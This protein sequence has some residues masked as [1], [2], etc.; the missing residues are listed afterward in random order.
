MKLFDNELGAYYSKNEQA[1][2]DFVNEL[3]AHKKQRDL[4]DRVV[5]FCPK[6]FGCDIKNRLEHEVHMFFYEGI[7]E[8]NEPYELANDRT[9]LILDGSSRYKNIGTRK[10]QR[11]SRLSRGFKHKFLVDQVPFSSDTKYIYLPYAYLSRDILGH[12]HFYA[13][14]ENN[15]ELFNGKLVGGL[16]HELLAH[17]IKDYAVI[18][19]KYF[20]NTNPETIEVDLTPSEKHEYDIRREQLFQKYDRFNPIV[21]RLADYSNTRESVYNK[22]EKLLKN[23]EGK[24]LLYTNIKSHNKR[25][26]KRFPDYETYTFY[27]TNGAEKEA[28]NIV[29]CEVPISR[30]YLFLDVLTRLKP[31]CNIFFLKPKTSVINYLYQQMTN[32]FNQIHDFTQKLWE[33]QKN[34]GTRKKSIS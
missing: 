12:Q 10:F 2:A 17:K 3:I 21:T 11:L 18:D 15:Q 22:L 27:D 9:L 23:I 14:R 19:Y 33:V 4:I 31:S 29:L 7:E 8:T 26:R 30:G 32:E 25:L 5:Y 24:T 1:R 16:D 6:K 34:E 13:F 20:L 28:D